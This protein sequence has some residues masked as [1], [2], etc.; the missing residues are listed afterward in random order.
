MFLFAL[1]LHT[2]QNMFSQFKKR[3]YVIYF[4][5]KWNEDFD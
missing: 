1:D 5:T 3:T 4:G 2:K